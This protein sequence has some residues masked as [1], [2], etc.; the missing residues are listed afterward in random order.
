MK[1]KIGFTLAAAAVAGFALVGPGEADS[2]FK[3]KYA[4]DGYVHTC[5]SGD[6]IALVGPTKLWPPNHKLQDL[7]IVAT[8]EAGG[9]DNPALQG[10]TLA[11]TFP[12]PLDA[13]GGDGGLQHG[14]D[15]I[16]T[17]A[18]TSSGE[19]SA[20]VPFQL[21]SERSGKGEGRTYLIKA[22]A[23][24]DGDPLL[25]IGTTSCSYTFEVV[26]PHDMRGGAD[27]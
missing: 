11:V 24:F 7:S 22:D 16:Y 14:P 17:G 21:R 10:T 6:T 3:N 20:A 1:R 15:M 26:V 4:S 18:P 27:W 2:S 25:G 19:G 9:T 13:V 5:D 12:E 23:T 8:D